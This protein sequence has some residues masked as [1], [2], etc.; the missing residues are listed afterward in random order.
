MDEFHMNPRRVLRL[1][2]VKKTQNPVVEQARRAQ[3][4]VSWANPTTAKKRSKTRKI[5]TRTS[6]V[7]WVHR[8]RRFDDR[9][10]VFDVAHAARRLPW[11]RGEQRGDDGARRRRLIERVKVYAG[12]TPHEQI[13]ALQ[14]GVCHTEI[15]NRFGF[16]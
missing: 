4:R 3:N 1:N 2:D 8:K 5:V 15:Q 14:R 16:A 9:V 12:R 6:R 11:P 13:D 10:G 7:E